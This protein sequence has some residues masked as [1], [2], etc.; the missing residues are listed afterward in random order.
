[1][2]H[3]GLKPNGCPQVWA[4]AM[5]GLQHNMPRLHDDHANARILA[6]GLADINGLEVELETVQTNM[7]YADVTAGNKRAAKLISQLEDEGVRAWNL[8]GRLR[9]VTS[10]LVDRSDCER[11]VQ[12]IGTA[13][14]EA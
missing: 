4:A 12:V 11:A 2:H 1:M 9:F 14:A 5:Y 10:M 6:E 8:G 3:S 13:M 7:V